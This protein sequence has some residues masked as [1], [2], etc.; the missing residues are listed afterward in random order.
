MLWTGKEPN[1]KH[2]KKRASCILTAMLLTALSAC[3]G[4]V[5]PKNASAASQSPVQISVKQAEDL[6]EVSVEETDSAATSAEETTSAEPTGVVIDAE[7]CQ[8]NGY[9]ILYGMYDFETYMELPLT[10]SGESLSY[11]CMIPPFM[12]NY[13]VDLND[14]TYYKEMEARTGVH[15]DLRVASFLN[16]SEQFNLMITAGEYADLLE[17]AVHNINGGGT[18]GIEDGILLDMTPYI[19]NNMPNYSAWM[20]NDP[21]VRAAVTNLDGTIA[22]AAGITKDEWNV[23]PQL[24]GDWLEALNLEVP[25]TYD[26]Y[27]EILKAFN[28]EYGATLWLDGNGTNRNNCLSAGYDVQVASFYTNFR[29]LDGTVEYSPATNDYF[30]FLQ[31]MNKWWNEGLIYKDFISQANVST[32]DNSLIANN[33]VGVWTTDTGNMMDYQDLS[34]EIQIAAAGQPRKSVGQT[35]HMYIPEY[36]SLDGVSMSSTCAEPELAAKWLDYN[37][38][39]D[40]VLL[41]NFGVEGEGMIFTDGKPGYSDLVLNNPEMITVACSVFYSKYSG[42]GV[43]D[44]NRFMDS[45]NQQQKDA[46]DLWNT[47]MDNSHELPNGVPMTVDETSQY[48]ALMSD[49]ETYVDQMRLSF[50]ISEKLTQADWDSYLDNLS[51]LD[52]D[53]VVEITQ[54]AYDRYLKNF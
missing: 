37:Y 46:I 51:Q 28:S 40:G 19:E 5:Q 20:D 10:D 35:L 6:A 48:S 43:M 26:D 11:W 17:G 27:Y 49:I 53:R 38:T 24:R 2:I 4:D 25:V 45:Y 23:G 42:A 1:M 44:E 30:E 36:A 54:M 7:T 8:A 47:N 50:I 39:Y 32:P 15:I 22:V 16:A 33:T 31:L 14:V 52:L 12:N 18:K 21:A 29:V 13:N 41:C 3:A 34:E 9:D